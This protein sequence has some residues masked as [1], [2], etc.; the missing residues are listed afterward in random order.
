MTA[1]A[2]SCLPGDAPGARLSTESGWVMSAQPT[3]VI[4]G[5]G[6]E[7]VRSR[8]LFPHHALSQHLQ[9][10]SSRGPGERLC[11]LTQWW[12]TVK[13]GRAEGP[14]HLLDN[15]HQGLAWGSNG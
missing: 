14:G 12:H 11:L 4:S 1:K 5:P 15:Q 2:A 9:H 8:L 7:G 3:S 10:T 6:V 13:L